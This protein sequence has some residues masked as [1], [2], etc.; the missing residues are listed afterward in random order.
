M[1]SR[2]VVIA[3]AMAATGALSLSVHVVMMQVLAIPYPEGYA[4]AVWQVLLTQLGV[5]LAAGAFVFLGR[6]RL[7]QWPV[8]WRVLVIALALAALREGL[9]RGPLMNG[10]TTSFWAQAV[11]ANLTFATELWVA[12]CWV[13]WRGWLARRVPAGMSGVWH[14]IAAVAITVSVHWIVSPLAREVPELLLPHL[15][16]P[17]PEDALLP[18]YGWT[19]LVPAYLSYAE[20]V[21]GCF[22]LAWLAWNQL[23]R[24]AA[25]RVLQFTVLVTF[26][27]GMALTPFFY[28]SGSRLPFMQGLLGMGQFSLEVIT[29]AVMVGLTMTVMYRQR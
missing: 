2:R 3:L 27:R 15:A 13:L 26:V 12:L 8:A 23:H 16:R 21:I 20:P 11:V 14:F 22:L 4:P 18:P 19:V 24:G 1:S 29:L 17:R 25:V 7:A 5:V 9:V 10:I 6:D 28:A